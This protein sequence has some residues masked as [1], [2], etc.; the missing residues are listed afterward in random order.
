MRGW[1]KLPVAGFIGV[2]VFLSSAESKEIE[3]NQVSEL[4]GYRNY[5]RGRFNNYYRNRQRNFG[6]YY[7]NNRYNNARINNGGYNLGY[8]R[9]GNRYNFRFNYGNN[10]NLN[11]NYQVNNANP[12]RPQRVLGRK[13][14]ARFL[15]EFKAFKAGLNQ[16]AEARLM[17]DNATKKA[18]DRD[19]AR[20]DGIHKKLKQMMEQRKKKP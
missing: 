16:R 3:D 8:G 9:Y 19:I 11:R 12:G 7:P 2:L 10:Y 13:E 5:G 1:S 20:H 6:N 17:K 14:K 15:D 4:F 18:F